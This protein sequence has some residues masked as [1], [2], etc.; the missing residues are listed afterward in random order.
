MRK[1]RFASAFQTLLFLGVGALLVMPIA[2]RFHPRDSFAQSPVGTPTPSPSEAPIAPTGTVSPTLSPTI[3]PS[4]SPS[5]TGTPTPS[6]SPSPTPL[7]PSP[8]ATMPPPTP[9]PTVV[10]PGPMEGLLRW[11]P[12]L[13][14]CGVVAIGLLVLTAVLLFRMFRRR[15]GPRR[16]TRPLPKA[17]PSP[18]WLESRVAGRLRRWPL[19]ESLTVGRAADNDLIITPEF[20]GWETVSRRHARIYRQGDHWIVEDLGSTNGIYVNGRRTGRNRL[21]DGWRLEIGGVAFT[22]RAGKGGVA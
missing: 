19:K 14:G 18:P 20:A 5:P 22:F 1:N 21:Q 12:A 4:P 15:P 9:P 17:P 8:S 6:P 3:S 16:P 10:G 13:I 11:Y 2:A 7:P